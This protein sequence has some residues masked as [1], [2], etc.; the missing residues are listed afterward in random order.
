MCESVPVVI[1]DY[2]IGVRYTPLRRYLAT[3]AAAHDPRADWSETKIQDLVLFRNQSENSMTQL[4]RAIGF[5]SMVADC[6][7][8]ISCALSRVR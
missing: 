7:Y 2:D 4:A 1:E 5:H 8:V 6:M 3:P